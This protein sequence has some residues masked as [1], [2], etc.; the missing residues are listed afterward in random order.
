LR[1]ITLTTIFALML[2]SVPA[3]GQSNYAFLSGTILDPQNRVLAGASV[4]LTSLSTRAA[5]RVSSNDQGIFQ[6]SG[7]LPDDYELN[8]QAPGFAALTQSLRLEVGQQLNLDLT[9]KLASVS[10][11]VEVEG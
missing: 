1:T 5:R 8:V 7:L 2:A 9:L 11:T 10:N 4:Q 6:I 3:F